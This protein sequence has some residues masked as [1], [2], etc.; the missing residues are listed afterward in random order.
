MDST[1]LIMGLVLVIIIA[2]PVF[3]LARKAKKDN[4]QTENAVKK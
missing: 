4:D 1:S 2:V 3:L